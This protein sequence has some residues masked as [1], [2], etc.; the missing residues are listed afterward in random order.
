MKLFL[1]LAF[2]LPLAAQD[3]GTSGKLTA[4]CQSPDGKAIDCD[5]VQPSNPELDKLQ[6][7]VAELEKELALQN[8]LVVDFHQQLDSC[9]IN[10]TVLRVQTAKPPVA[11][12]PAEK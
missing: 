12:K 4:A 5:K 11:P 6:A 7:R 8:S 10:L 2:A 1:V 3:T 9:N